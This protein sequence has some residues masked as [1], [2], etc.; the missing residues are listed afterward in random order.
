MNQTKDIIEKIII[1]Y[2][3]GTELSSIESRLAANDFT[4]KNFKDAN[5]RGIDPKTKIN[6]SEYTKR[7]LFQLNIPESEHGI[8]ISESASLYELLINLYRRDYHHV[9]YLISMIDEA[10]PKNKMPFWVMPGIIAGIVS[11]I[12]GLL[13]HYKHD[14]LMKFLEDAKELAIKAFD[15]AKSVFSQAKNVAFFG[16]G[17]NALS[18]LYNAISVIK[19]D[20]LTNPQ[21][22]YELLFLITATSLTITSYIVTFTMGGAMSLV[23]GSLMIAAS[24]ISIIKGAISLYR[25]YK[26]FKEHRDANIKEGQTPQELAQYFRKKY[27]YNA[28]KSSLFVEIGGAILATAIVA[29]WSFF[30][31]SIALIAVCIGGL[32][33]IQA[34]SAYLSTK[35]KSHYAQELQQ[36]ISQIENIEDEP[37]PKKDLTQDSVVSAIHTLA[38]LSKA[39]IPVEDQVE[40]SVQ[41]THDKQSKTVTTSIVLPQGFVPGM[42][43]SVQTSVDPADSDNP[44]INVTTE[45]LAKAKTTSKPVLA[46]MMSSMNSPVFSSTATSKEQTSSTE[47]SLTEQPAI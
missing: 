11:L 8:Y 9:G 15:W 42:K 41:V 2:L 22:G 31:P 25:T 20:K 7:I 39:Q 35:I 4:K 3:T 47:L 34:F 38:D 30:P 40:P 43:I 23:A 28:K 37:Q 27:D 32:T 19:D 16:V 12:I 10:K 6:N 29:A 24:A 21:K 44:N 13:E 36:K 1:P 5:P 26:D 46:H 14:A 33:L 17:F 45:S 18:F